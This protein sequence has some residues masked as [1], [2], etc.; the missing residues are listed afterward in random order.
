MDSIGAGGFGEKEAWWGVELEGR[1][2]EVG[3]YCM[4]E[5]IKVKKKK[6]LWGGKYSISLKRKSVVQYL[7]KVVIPPSL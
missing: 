5:Y 3:M 6:E 7:I 1:E 4:R 2:P